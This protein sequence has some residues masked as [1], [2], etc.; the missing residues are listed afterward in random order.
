MTVDNLIYV[1][2]GRNTTNTL[3]QVT[4]GE[5]LLVPSESQERKADRRAAV[6][7]SSSE[8]AEKFERLGPIDPTEVRSCD[9]DVLCRQLLLGD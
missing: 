7:M 8:E 9:L 3:S 4:R 5:D 6:E 1:I 2:G